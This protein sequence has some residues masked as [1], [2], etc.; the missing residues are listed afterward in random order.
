MKS[1][2]LVHPWL[3]ALLEQE[4]AN[5]GAFVQ[6]N[7]APSPSPNPD[8]AKFSD[9]EFDNDDSLPLLEPELLSH[10]A[11]DHVVPMDRE[12]RARRFVARLRQPFGALS[13]TPVSSSRRGTDYRRVAADSLITV[14]FQENVLLASILDN[15]RTLD[16]L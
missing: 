3:D 8:D 13:L 15:V 12:T 5:S 9:E 6:D 10:F 1:L 4:G 16:V 11:A 7:V 14:R 2:Y